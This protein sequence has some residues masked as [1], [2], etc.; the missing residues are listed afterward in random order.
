MAQFGLYHYKVLLF[1]QYGGRF[2]APQ[3]YTKRALATVTTHD[4]PTLKSYWDGHDI[5]LRRNLHLYPNHEIEREVAEARARDREALVTALGEQGLLPAPGFDTGHS[6]TPE[7]AQALHVYLA[8]STATLAAVQIEDL[9][10]MEEPVNIPGTY[11]EYPNWQRKVSQSIE[12]VAARQD[13]AA[14]LDAI[15][16]ARATG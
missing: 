2:R 14:H 7:L 12:V 5:E 11:T 15:N 4:M 1:E 10:G 13:L 8:R 3:D 16:A 9:L 6:F